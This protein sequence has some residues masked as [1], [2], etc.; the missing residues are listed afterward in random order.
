M[1]NGAL[2]PH[3][4]HDLLEGV[5]QYE[6]KLML[7]YMINIESYFTMDVLQSRME[8][9]ELSNSESAYNLNSKNVEL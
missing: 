3:V 5:M 2:V 9:L 4:M 8:N 6:V 7:R 1:C